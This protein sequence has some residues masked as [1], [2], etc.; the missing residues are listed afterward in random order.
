MCG[1]AQIKKRELNYNSMRSMYCHGYTD[2]TDEW[3]SVPGQYYKYIN[4][5]I[6]NINHN[7]QIKIYKQD[8][9]KWRL[10]IYLCLKAC[11]SDDIRL[12]ND[13]YLTL[14][15]AK[16]S[17]IDFIKLYDCTEKAQNDIDNWKLQHSKPVF[18]IQANEILLIGTT[19][20]GIEHYRTKSGHFDYYNEDIPE[21]ASGEYYLLEKNWKGIYIWKC[22]L[23]PG[24]YIESGIKDEQLIAKML[25]I[26]KD[27]PKYKHF[28]DHDKEEND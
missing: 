5:W 22:N 26:I 12:F 10:V 28:L 18:I 7:Y 25:D 19:Y 2:I 8:K 27:I 16:I 21:C 14:K 3:V 13:D 17:A 11:N 1:N 15:E 24:S 20:T 4:N 23:S 9:N 6:Y